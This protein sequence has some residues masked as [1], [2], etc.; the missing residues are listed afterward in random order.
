LEG[1]LKDTREQVNHKVLEEMERLR[2]M[3]KELSLRQVG[4]IKEI[5]DK[6]KMLNNLK[7]IVRDKMN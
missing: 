7:T 3:E 2:E 5:E 4:M 6:C 1:N